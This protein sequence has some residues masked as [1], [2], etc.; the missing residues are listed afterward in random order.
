MMRREIDIEARRLLAENL[1][2]FLENQITNDDLLYGFDDNKCATIYMKSSDPGVRVIYAR[3]C[4]T[5]DTYSRVLKQRDFGELTAEEL[6][7]LSRA[8][9]FLNS[10]LPYEWPDRP[11]LLTALKLL[12]TVATFGVFGQY[13]TKRY[14]RAGDPTVW[15]FIRRTDFELSG[16]TGYDKEVNGMVQGN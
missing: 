7:E 2:L 5:W 10:N 11:G 1:R 14:E 3:C 9:S 4:R 16:R 8:I 12:L 13:W 15:P 6:E